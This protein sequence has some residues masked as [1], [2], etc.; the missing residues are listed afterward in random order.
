MKNEYQL[1]K[2]SIVG[3]GNSKPKR[4]NIQE[5]GARK[6]KDILRNWKKIN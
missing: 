1:T 5:S 2:Q 4:K 6:H 3:R